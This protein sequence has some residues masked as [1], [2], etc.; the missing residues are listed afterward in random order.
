MG[1]VACVRTRAQLLTLLLCTYI[2][3]TALAQK[4]K[5]VDKGRM[6]IRVD[7]GYYHTAFEVLDTTLFDKVEK[8]QVA[9]SDCLDKIRM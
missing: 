9:L 8:F 6:S 3:I 7:G 1:A 5:T 2:P 4:S